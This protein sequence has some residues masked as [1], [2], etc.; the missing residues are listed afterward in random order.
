MKKTLVAAIIAFSLAGCAT[1]G[2]GSVTPGTISE[3]ARQIQQ[4]TATFC[5]FVPTIQTI[6]SIIN[7]GAGSALG[8]ATDI[9]TA[10]TTAPLADGG[11]RKVAVR[12]VR[13]KGQFVR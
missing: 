3:T 13:I 7:T 8:I 12:G 9:C 6:V 4:Y 5:K 2:P 1:T 11:T 10:I